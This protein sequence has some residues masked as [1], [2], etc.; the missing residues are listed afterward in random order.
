[1]TSL[2]G[3]ENFQGSVLRIRRAISFTKPSMIA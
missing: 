1:M 3:G 2:K